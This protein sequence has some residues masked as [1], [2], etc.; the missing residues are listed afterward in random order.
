MVRMSHPV[1]TGKP[2]W[3][4][5]GILNDASESSKVAALVHP[6]TLLATI[7]TSH[8]KGIYRLA[9]RR[10]LHPQQLNIFRERPVEDVKQPASIAHLLMSSSIS[11]ARHEC[12]DSPF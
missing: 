6:S 10:D 4:A 5:A 9:T 11:Q 2:E 1:K 8:G 3:R 12:T 7:I